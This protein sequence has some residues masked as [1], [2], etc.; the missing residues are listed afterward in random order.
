[1]TFASDELRRLVRF[2]IV[3][4]ASNAALYLVFLLLLQ[5]AVPPLWA[6]AICYALGVSV[7]YVANRAWSF[8]SR[9]PHRADLPK[10]LVAHGVC[11]IST[12]VVLNVLLVWLRPEL[13]Q[14][15]NVAVMAVITYL[16]LALLGFGGA[17]AGRA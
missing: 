15:V 14:L 4:V 17:R 12:I 3:G 13:A 1:V 5:L 8:E 16:T 11:M 10:F 9:D 6:A 7:S 2:A